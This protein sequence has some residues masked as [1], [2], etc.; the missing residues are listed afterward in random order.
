MSIS[1]P[2]LFL[3]KIEKR[4]KGVSRSDFIRQIIEKSEEFTN[5]KKTN[6]IVYTPLNLAEYVASKTLDYCLSN[7]QIIEGKTLNVLDPACGEGALLSAVASI[8]KNRLKPIKIKFYGVDIDKTALAKAVRKLSEQN[9]RASNTNGL[10][11][12]NKTSKKG[13]S[14]LQKM[15]EVRNGVDV[16]IANPPW[17]ASISNYRNLIER[18]D[19]KLFSG[20]FDTSDLFVE[21]ALKNV[22]E[23]GFLSFIVPDSLF[24][25]ERTKLRELLLTKT[26]ICFIGRFGEKI[27]KDVNRA[28]A[29][30]ICQKTKASKSH[31]VDCFRLSTEHKNLILSDKFTFKKSES[32]LGHKVLQSRF[33][34][35][36]KL[37]FNI[38]IDR[39]L[40]EVFNKILSHKD[41]LKNYIRGTRGVEL[42]KKG[43][44]V[45][46]KICKKWSPFP[47]RDVLHC[48]HCK[49]D[50]ATSECN[51]EVI[52][53]KN[54]TKNSRELIVGEHIKRY[55]STTDLWLDMTKNGLKYKNDSIY[56][57]P[58]LI[59][60]KTGIGISASIDYKEH[61][62]N[63]V[64]YIFKVL[65]EFLNKIPLE[66]FLLI[67]NS[68]LAYFLISMSNGE[69]EW[70]S[71]PYITQSQIL[72]FPIP[73]I[74]TVSLE[75]RERIINI[76]K[77]IALLLSSGKQISNSCD[78][79]LEKLV[80]DL[81][82]LKE[83][84]YVAIFTTIEKSQELLSVKALKN[85]S[86]SDIFDVGAN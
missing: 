23:G 57:S 49:Q 22:K 25:H 60:R 6:G 20:Q 33:L 35:N 65:P 73:N 16:I 31:K 36:D 44:V 70:K 66:L 14:K 19:F 7:N 2:E 85:I 18:S 8:N 77:E 32:Q 52:I 26:K 55:S 56:R 74:K 69:I 30:V 83:Q 40:E 4:R 29:V 50:V 45:E 59:I 1:V 71:H 67:L 78:A 10:C 54:K 75:L 38:D 82:G 3:E 86:K 24:A 43:N 61:L 51:T 47:S 68:R 62:T 58:K 37:L 41:K 34:E 79:K 28:C 12:Y 76:S 63:Q 84:D 15:L 39:E 21:M 46:C 5:P 72:E 48:S 80:A 9:F 27:F 11:P 53:H 17:G 64:V 81:Y 13:W 42:S